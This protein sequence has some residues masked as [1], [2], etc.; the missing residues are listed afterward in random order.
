MNPK[1]EAFDKLS[2]LVEILGAEAVL[3]EFSLKLSADELEDILEAIETEYDLE[4]YV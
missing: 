2:M 3:N 4:P 1:S